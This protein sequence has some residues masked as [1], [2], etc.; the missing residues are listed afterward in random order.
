VGHRIRQWLDGLGLSQYADIFEANDFDLDLI[1]DVGD[2]DL[3]DLGVTSM[4]HR[5]LLLRSIEGLGAGQAS[6]D[7]RADTAQRPAERR[8]LT[9]MFCDLVGSTALSRQ[10]DPEDLRDVMRRYQDVVAGAVTRYGGHVAKYLG[11]GVLAYFGWPQAYEDQAER[12]VRAGLDAVASVQ[13]VEGPDGHALAA[14]VG[15]AT[16]QVVVGD[17]VGE[18]GR[19]AEAVSGETPNRAARLQQLAEPGQVVVGEA[20][21]Q[22]VDAAFTLDDLGGHE[23]KGFDVA[24]RAWRVA[25]QISA[26]S[27]FEAA[28]GAA[29]TRIV[30]R[31]T[32][33][34][35]LLERWRRAEGGEGQVVLISGEAG[36][37]KSRLMQALSDH[38]ADTDHTRVR[39]QCSPY[40]TNSAFYPTIQHLERAAGF[41]AEDDGDD[42]LDKLVSLLG[43][44]GDDV[45]PDLPFFA[46]L[47]SL[48]YEERHGALEQSPQQIKEHQLEMLAAYLLRLAEQRPVLFFFED[49][50][51]IDPTSLEM[52]DLAIGRLRR[53]R[54]LLVLS[55]RPD[56]LPPTDGHDHVTLLQLNRLGNADG[57]EIV[58]AIAG[59]SV[60]EDSIARIVSRTD[61]VPLFVEELTKSL[62]EGGLDITE[63]D[64]P[65]TLQA[66]LL[67]RLDRLGTAAKEIAQIGSVI[68]RDF[69]HELLLRVADRPD[70]E[71][72][73]DLDHLVQSGLVLR[74]G[75]SPNVHYTFKHALVQDAAYASMLQ[76]LCRQ[77]HRNVAEA[78]AGLSPKLLEMQPELLAFHYEKGRQNDD[79][80]TWWRRAGDLAAKRSQNREAVAHYRAAIDV[81][82][83]L[84][85]VEAARRLELALQ[86]KIGPMLTMSEGNASEAVE[87]TYLRADELID[88]TED[89]AVVFPTKWHLWYLYEQRT[90]LDKSRAQA[91]ELL[92]L[93]DQSDD[94]AIVIEANHAAW[95]SSTSR[96]RWEH[97]LERC[98]EGIELFDVKRHGHLMYDI[99]GH[100]PLICGLVH[101]RW[102]LACLGYANQANDYLVRAENRRDQMDH[103]PS[104]LMYSLGNVMF[105][106]ILNDLVGLRQH[107]E[108]ARAICE[109][110]GAT[111]YLGI[112]NVMDGWCLARE[113]GGPSALDQIEAGLKAFTDT[114]ARL[115]VPLYLSCLADA[116]RLVGRHGAGL[117]AVDKAVAMIAESNQHAFLSFA[118]STKGQ[119]LLASGAD[120]AEAEHVFQHALREACAMKA[121]WLELNAA[122]HLARLWIDK[123][124][125][126]EADRLLRPLYDWF[127]EGF[128]KQDLIDAKA[129][130][131][132]SS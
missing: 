97:C 132:A 78:I 113:G 52:L 114:G 118:L 93:A 116:A 81:V 94:E 46:D 38:L 44:A 59:D 65:A 15:I 29:L 123:G 9:V 76:S 112:T 30:G 68:G 1:R 70:T 127:T 17:L 95:T 48:P 86:L 61:G 43:Q 89:V 115:R 37:G 47:L 84:E 2:A 73:A 34:Q 49:A 69:E 124:R 26:E 126:E 108:E 19:D 119:L 7:D 82:R 131:D 33:L 71:L 110:I 63:A 18:S 80:V 74:A 85:N 100:D 6:V 96:G 99:A 107:I 117:D 128:D 105:V 27:R 56:W 35:L 12:A 111:A 75:R 20:T 83:R 60:S 24:V 90:E 16:G 13:D 11:D 58:R 101:G 51:W 129:L 40:H 104:R 32:E 67:A 39:Y 4:G 25:G 3:K 36:I 121:R 91:E 21:R 64:I 88:D 22:L 130:L 125:R 41:A 122:N 66:S 14:R 54:V 57:A 10:L 106:P 72:S 79:A 45:M 42:K 120:P 5:K 77:V 8:Q 109:G 53:A 50:H 87:S 103:L 62:V 98:R 31:E 23:L 28:H 55:H 102:A 92:A